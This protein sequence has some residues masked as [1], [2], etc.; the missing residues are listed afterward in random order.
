MKK[1]N[2]GG[3]SVVLRPLVSTAC[4][5]GAFDTSAC[6]DS[7]AAMIRNQTWAAN[8]MWQAADLDQT[9]A[10]DPTPQP[11]HAVPSVA[12]SSASD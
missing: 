5:Q 7:K 8:G 10:S 11:N 4:P 9:A 1:R 6:L 2:F 12:T 3:T